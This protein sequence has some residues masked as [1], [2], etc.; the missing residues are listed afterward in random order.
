MTGLLCAAVIGLAG[1]GEDSDSAGSEKP[2]KTAAPEPAAT[3][4]ESGTKGAIRIVTKNMAF[5][6]QYV[7]A[8]VGQTLEFANEDEV[9]HSVE[10]DEGQ[11]FASKTLKP[12][13]TF[14]V[15]VKDRKILTNIS[16]F[17]PIHPEKM[18]GGITVSK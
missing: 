11:D 4:V 8:R 5:A 12:G 18:S 10:T 13:D 16:Y 3:T 17:C 7:S 2:A 9:A 15:K 14:T 1:C 6:P